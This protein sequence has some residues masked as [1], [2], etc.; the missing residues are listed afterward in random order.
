VSTLKDK[1]A[2]ATL[3]ESLAVARF[4]KLA[5]HPLAQAAIELQSIDQ[6]IAEVEASIAVLT[7]PLAELQ[8][9]V[10]L[11]SVQSRAM[12]ATRHPR[13]LEAFKL[14]QR[15][16]FRLGELQKQFPPSETLTRAKALLAWLQEQRMEAWL[17]WA[18]EKRKADRVTR[19]RVKELLAKERPIDDVKAHE[20]LLTVRQAALAGAWG[21][22]RYVQIGRIY[23]LP[24][25]D[26]IFRCELDA[27]EIERAMRAG[28]GRTA[29]KEVIRKAH[30]MGLW[31]EIIRDYANNQPRA[32]WSCKKI[33]KEPRK[34]IC[35]D[36]YVEK[37]NRT[38]GKKRR[39]GEWAQ[40]TYQPMIDYKR[41]PIDVRWPRGIKDSSIWQEEDRREQW[42]AHLAEG[43]NPVGFDEMPVR[44]AAFEF[45]GLHKYVVGVR[46]HVGDSILEVGQ[47][48]RKVLSGRALAIKP[49]NN[50]HLAGSVS[51]PAPHQHYKKKGH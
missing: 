37:H 46:D 24:L 16:Q 50:G 31:M 1:W 15:W 11:L 2:G 14:W 41:L 21:I 33:I 36:C 49:L 35:D 38:E 47:S 10:L 22:D 3:Q 26:E 5:R 34:L 6:L 20:L 44:E 19:H 42:R 23:Q 28:K 17:R 7:D 9:Q 48:F 43:G 27:N 8:E 18:G 25:H 45:G 30:S 13:K 32:C 40:D 51:K 4:G 12:T 39:P 29:A